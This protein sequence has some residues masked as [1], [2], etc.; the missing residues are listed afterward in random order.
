MCAGDADLIR[1]VTC[2]N[3][4]QNDSV[5]HNVSVVYRSGGTDYL[6]YSS[7]MQPGDNL[8][9]DDEYSLNGV[10]D[11]LVGLID[12]VPSTDDMTYVVTFKYKQ[13]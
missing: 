8:V 11:E 5:E 12:G 10:G 13:T 9:I 6:I 1:V 4:Q 7:T 3:I 2:I